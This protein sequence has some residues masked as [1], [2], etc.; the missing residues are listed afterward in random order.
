MARSSIENV[1]ADKTKVTEELIDRYFKM[2]LREGN[3]Q[4]LVDRMNAINNEKNTYL[5]INTIQQP[6]LI[7]WGDQDLLVPLSN[8]HQFHKDLPNSSLV[9]LKDVGHVPMEES[10]IESLAAFTAFLNQ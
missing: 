10:P 2:T 4:A 1:Y 5:Q 9:I 8:A 6:T 7:L 3:R